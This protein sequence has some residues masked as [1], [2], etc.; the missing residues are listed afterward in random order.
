M[1]IDRLP[2]K[3]KLTILVEG[4]VDK[5]IVD[6]IILRLCPEHSDVAVVAC[7]GKH[8]VAKRLS[9]SMDADTRVAALVDAD[10][11]S[12]ADSVALA[13]SQLGTNSHLVFCA[14]PCIEAWLF[15]D[16]RVAIKHAR[17]KMARQTAERLPL[18]ELIP[19][20]KYVAK[21]IFDSGSGD[22]P[23]AIIREMDFSVSIGRSPSF[24]AFINGIQVELG[25]RTLR[26]ERA[27]SGSVS[28]DAISTIVRE[29][30]GDSIVWKTVD[31][32]AMTA[33]RLATEV[34]EG[35]EIGKQYATE[36]LRVARDLIV[37]RSSRS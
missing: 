1:T 16:P 2:E 10:V 4:E 12:V 26:N 21:E 36:L 24:A 11:V 17:S 29:L 37:R 35:T 30:P 18:P 13:K 3:N 32:T 23:E 28:R 34:I 22:Y 7:G 19:Y 14:V 8:N 6:Q 9:N 15:A 31:G 20:P 27:L 25:V 5:I 33:E